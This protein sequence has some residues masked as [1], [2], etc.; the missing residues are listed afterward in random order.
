MSVIDDALFHFFRLILRLIFSVWFPVRL[1]S[2]FYE[3]V[4]FLNLKVAS[5]KV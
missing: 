1:Y 3:T 2:Y 5:I 4:N